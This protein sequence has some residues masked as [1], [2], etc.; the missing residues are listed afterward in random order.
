MQAGDVPSSATGPSEQH[1][2]AVAAE[3][4]DMT[5]KDALKLVD[6]LIPVKP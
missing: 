5:L 6:Q 4:P 3:K 2:R 1:G